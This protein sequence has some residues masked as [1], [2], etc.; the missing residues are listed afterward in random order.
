MNVSYFASYCKKHFVLALGLRFSCVAEFQGWCLDWNSDEE[1]CGLMNS[2]I[3]IPFP[4]ALDFVMFIEQWSVI[5]HIAFCN[6]I[7]ISNFFHRRNYWLSMYP[8]FQKILFLQLFKK[9]LFFLNEMKC[10]SSM[11]SRVK[12]KSSAQFLV[13]LLLRPSQ[14]NCIFWIYNL[15][16]IIVTLQ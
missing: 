7:H 11:F 2:S 1:L 13:Y 16:Q 4:L 9:Y 15:S 5:H 3:N 6:G 8:E 12:K 10:R 14:N